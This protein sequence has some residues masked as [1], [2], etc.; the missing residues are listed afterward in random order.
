MNESISRSVDQLASWKRR[1]AM[2]LHTS[3]M[4]VA[5]SAYSTLLFIFEL[6]CFSVATTSSLSL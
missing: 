1:R 2:G 6:L 5:A 4:E 3:I